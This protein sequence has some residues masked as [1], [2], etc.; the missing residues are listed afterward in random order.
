MMKSVWRVMFLLAL[1]SVYVSACAVYGPPPPIDVQPIAS[2]KYKQKVDHLYFVL[3]ASH[4]MTEGYGG[5][6]KFAT[7]RSVVK[8]F[9][10]T[11]PSVNV[12][13]GMRSFGH[14]DKVS[15]KGSILAVKSKRYIPESL[16]GGLTKVYKAGG[17]SPLDRALK[18]AGKDLKNVKEPI[19]LVI[20]SDGKDMMK[21]TLDAAKA[22]KATHGD[23]LC[24]YT[25]LVGNDSSGKKLLSKLAATTGCGKAVNADS[26]ATGAAMKAFVKEVL[27][28]DLADS[29]G[30]G[31]TDDKD[32]C[33][34]TPRGVKVDRSGCAL[35]SDGDGVAD[36]KDKCPNTPKGA[37]VDASG[38]PLAALTKGAEVTKAGTWIYKDIQF[39]VNKAD[40][41]ESS[42]PTLNEIVA[43]LNAQ[44]NL[45]IEIQ[46]H[47]DSTGSH[48][49]NVGLS[50]KRAQSVKNYLA[51]KG[52][53]G[54]RMTYKGFG[55][56]QPIAT[57][58][59]KAGRARNRRVEIKPIQ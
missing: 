21:E 59:T 30:D 39:E 44:P 46:G 11:M 14:H 17:S 29:D 5:Y 36:Y 3:D 26:L 2:G 55:P 13:V 27:F 58:K 31:V 20:V 48:A 23:R 40:L 50:Q 35:D 47:T 18:D 57:N 56:D 53:D 41:R 45:K 54:K 51:S 28:G 37:K 38:C 8:N 15:K 34:N 1:V 32:K 16:I 33:P 25:V 12:K 43:A 52:I 22:L 19:A 24:I 9:N 49:Y 4:S 7:A 42:Y 10:K 6:E